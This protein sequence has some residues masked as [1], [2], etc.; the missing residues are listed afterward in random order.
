VN[1]A[2]LNGL[3]ASAFAPASGSANYIQNQSGISQTASFNIAGNAV[4]GGNATVVSNEQVTGYLRLGS[5]TNTASGPSY[6]LGSAGLVI[7]RIAST[8]LTSGTLVA[9]T[10]QLQLQRDGTASG[11]QMAYVTTGSFQAVINAFGITTNGTMVVYRHTVPSPGSG[12]LAIFTDSQKLVHYDISFGN[13]YNAIHT[14]H[15]VVDRYDDGSTSDYFLVGTMT[16]TY[17]Q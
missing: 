11:L 14:C 6:P 15:V 17:N 7:R 12:T 1:A 2:L 10:D 3:P 9:R 16:T 5:E 13:T 4:I 8:S